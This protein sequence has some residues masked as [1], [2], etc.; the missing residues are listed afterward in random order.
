MEA[1]K[2]SKKYR[3]PSHNNQVFVAHAVRD[4]N[5]VERNRLQA[6]QFGLF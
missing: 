6:R 5:I 1:E 2:A 4:E 3:S